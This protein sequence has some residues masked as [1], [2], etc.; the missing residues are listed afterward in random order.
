MVRR[1]K[2]LTPLDAHPTV[3]AIRAAPSRPRPDVLDA[4]E[5]R[6][7]CREAGADDVGFVEISRPALADQVADITAA[8]PH[9]RALVS[10]VLRT[11]VEAVRSPARSVGN[12]EFHQTYDR[13]NEVARRIVTA[14]QDRGVRALNP[15]VGFP[16]EMQHWPGRIWVVSH[17]PVAVEAGLGRMGIHRNVIHPRFGN[18][19]LLATLVI[20]TPVSAYGRPLGYNPCLECKL[21]VAACPTGAIS[22]TGEFDFSACASHN[23]REFLTGFGDWVENVASSSSPRAYREKVSD[24]ETVSMWQSL[25][26]GPQYKAAYCVSVCP[27]GEDVIGPYLDDRRAHLDDVVKPLQDKVETVYV[28]AGSDAEAYVPRRFPHKRVQRAGFGIRPSSVASFVE[29][30]PLLFQRGVAAALDARYH[31]VFV[32]SEQREVTVEIRRGML[33]V[34]DGLHGRPDLRLDADATTW[35]RF[36]GGRASLPWAL[37]RRRFRLRGSPRLLA[38]F[39]RCFPT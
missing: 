23:Y 3:V 10:V 13:T 5:L 36:L 12:L 29:G 6:A 33:T 4:D 14:L 39:A 25:S 35:V 17:K 11:N 24:P 1:V 27:A 16:M 26:F 9:P 22:T 7:L 31:L 37:A 38:A 30:M 8:F 18:F 28:I 34:T 32:G 20:D 2:R 15:S 21:C 19:V